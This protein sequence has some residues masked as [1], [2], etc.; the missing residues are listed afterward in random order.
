MTRLQDLI[1]ICPCHLEYGSQIGRILPSSTFSCFSFTS[2]LATCGNIL[3]H[4]SN[5]PFHHESM[6]IS[7]ASLQSKLKNK[8]ALQVNEAVIKLPS[9][10]VLLFCLFRCKSE[11]CLVHVT[12]NCHKRLAPNGS[13]RHCVGL[14]DRAW[15]FRLCHHDDILAAG[16]LLPCFLWRTSIGVRAV[17]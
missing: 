12:D 8:H 10:T 11:I 5:A 3:Y 1:T 9:E 13:A 2:S 6:R 16:R 4:L 17:S 15:L 14:F 7:S